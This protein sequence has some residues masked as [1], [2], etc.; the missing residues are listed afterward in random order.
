M[1]LETDFWSSRSG[2]KKFFRNQ[3]DGAFMLATSDSALRRGPII[4]W[5]TAR[6]YRRAILSM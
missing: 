1:K 6:Y 5:R 3:N 2:R 4:D